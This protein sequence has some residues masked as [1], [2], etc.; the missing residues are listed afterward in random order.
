MFRCKTKKELEEEKK[1]KRRDYREIS[2]TKINVQKQEM[3]IKLSCEQEK[4]IYNESSHRPR[5]ECVFVFRKVFRHQVS[6]QV[7][8][9]E[10]E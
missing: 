5:V 2:T 3:E 9:R 7:S 10:R 6:D 8:M 4:N 1:T